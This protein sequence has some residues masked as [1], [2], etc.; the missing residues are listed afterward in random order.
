PPSPGTSTHSTAWR[1]SIQTPRRRQEVEPHRPLLG[2]DGPLKSAEVD[3]GAGQAPEA[4]DA[5]QAVLLPRQPGHGLPCLYRLLGTKGRS[6]RQHWSSSSLSMVS[7][8]TLARSRAISSSRPSAGRLLRAAWPA[9]RKSSRQPERVAAVTPSSRESSSRSSPRRRR[10]TAAVLRWEEKRPR[11]A[12][13]V[14]LDMGSAPG[15]GRNV[16]PTG[17]PTEPR[18]GGS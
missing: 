14:V 16:V 5:G 9:A 15:S 4:A 7:S 10:R 3:G 2:G 12:V 13:F 17:C 18:S 11:S 1:P 6:A 8:P